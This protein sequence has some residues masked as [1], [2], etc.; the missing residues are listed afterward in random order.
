MAAIDPSYEERKAPGALDGD[1][2][3]AMPVAGDQEASSRFPQLDIL[4]GVRLHRRP[5]DSA[6]E[7]TPA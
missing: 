1:R 3:S 7:R 5:L 2:F 4:A 6:V